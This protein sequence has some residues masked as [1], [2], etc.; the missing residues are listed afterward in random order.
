MTD[1]I[2]KVIRASAGTG[3]TY[4]LSLEYIGLLLKFQKHGIH[5]SEILVITFT[6]KAT[7][8]IRER[9]FEHI[10]EI[11]NQTNE[12]KELSKNLKSILNV[13]VTGDD[14][15]MLKAVYH[16]MLMNKAQVQIS[17]I[18]AFTHKIFKTIIGPYLGMNN[19]E[20]DNRINEELLAELY[21]SILD[22]YCNK[23]EPL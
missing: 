13:T 20:I 1:F 12:G 14:L 3:K 9:I 7:A 15:I 18:D 19:F 11:V 4:R 10:E 6:K 17:T 2:K 22:E 8:E 23:K 16:E 21:Q 5:F